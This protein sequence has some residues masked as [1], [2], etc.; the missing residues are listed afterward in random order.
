VKRGGVVLSISA[1]AVEIE[2]VMRRGSKSFSK[3]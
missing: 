1:A 2:D 3:R